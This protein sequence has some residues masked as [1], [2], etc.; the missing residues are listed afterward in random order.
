MAVLSPCP[1]NVL[2]TSITSIQ[3]NPHAFHD[4]NVSQLTHKCVSSTA[5][6]THPRLELSD[7]P[8]VRVEAAEDQSDSPLIHDNNNVK[9][10]N[11]KR[12]QAH[13][14][15]HRRSKLSLYHH[16]QT[17][18]T[19]PSNSLITLLHTNLHYRT[20]ACQPQPVHS[21]TSK[22]IHSLCTPLLPLQE[23]LF[24]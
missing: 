8:L 24:E 16:R 7:E 15:A 10:L 22:Y 5:N 12:Q 14:K 2:S 4:C 17:Y 9:T 3:S 11:N 6:R 20:Q 18:N 13:R 19:V 1:N 21:F 23:T